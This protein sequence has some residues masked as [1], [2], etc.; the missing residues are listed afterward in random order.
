MHY[1][2]LKDDFIISEKAFISID[3]RSFRFGDG[4][5]ETILVINKKI[6][7]LDSHL[8]R[9][10][11]GLEFLKI[12]YD[13]SK[14]PEWCNEL[15][16]KNSLNTGYLRL[17]ISRGLN[18]KASLGYKP[19]N[20]E[21][22]LIIQSIEKAIPDF[23]PV[24][25]SISSYRAFYHFPS[26]INSAY[27]YTLSM[28]EAEEKGLDNSLILDS[29]GYIC[30]TASANLFW[31]RGDELFTPSLKLPL[32]GGIIRKKI[33]EIYDGKIEEGFFKLEDLLDA[34]EIFITNVGCLISGV[35]EIPEISYKKN[36]FIKTKK[37]RGLLLENLTRL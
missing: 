5:F 22:Y 21:P 15:L 34:E 24:K 25:L 35:L 18:G 1:T 2:F 20:T 10:K 29:E 8:E 26:K 13:I 11:K 27:L 6:Y 19:Q 23:S 4:L 14:I 28:L 31:F 16:E 36:S 32:I 37:L 33:M 3:D 17:I 7:E 9:L 30:E 12:N